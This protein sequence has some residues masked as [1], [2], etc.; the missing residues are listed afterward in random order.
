MKK[1]FAPIAVF[2]V[3][4]TM[5]FVFFFVYSN[6]KEKAANKLL[7]LPELQLEAT[8]PTT[9]SAKYF[10]SYV[11]SDDNFEL[12]IARALFS[13]DPSKTG[14]DY[15][16]GGGVQEEQLTQVGAL[17]GKIVSRKDGFYYSPRTSSYCTSMPIFT[18]KYPDYD[19][20]KVNFTF[21]SPNISD[22]EKQKYTQIADQI[23]LSLKDTTK[24]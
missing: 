4:A 5:T 7:V 22:L 19:G 6:R 18:K 9:F 17:G 20:I 11:V 3:V 24:Q 12:E 21:K 14:G 2:L 15:C 13:E 1:I 23:V 10:G 8:V 16:G